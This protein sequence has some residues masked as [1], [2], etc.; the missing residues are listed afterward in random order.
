MID[1]NRIYELRPNGSSDRRRFPR[2]EVA[3][4]CKISITPAVRFR[5]AVTSDVSSGGVRLTVDGTDGFDVGDPVVL[6]V[7]WHGHP[8]VTHGETIPARVVRVE[9]GEDRTSLALAFETPIAMA[10]VIKPR[11]AA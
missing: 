5:A 1:Q 4:A 3:R 2:V 7:S 10:T 9:P 11:R 6:A 8:T